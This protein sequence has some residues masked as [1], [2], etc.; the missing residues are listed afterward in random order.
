MPHDPPP[1]IRI[2]LIITELHI[3][4]AERCLVEL[5]KRLDRAKYEPTVYSL[6]PPPPQNQ[7]ALVEELHRA[8]IDVRFLGA[9]SWLSSPRVLIS[10]WRHLRRQRPQIVQSFLF[11]ANFFAAIAGRI[12]GV[13]RVIAGIR[14]AEPRKWHLQ[15]ARWTDRWITK[16]VCVSQAVASFSHTTGGLPLEKLELIPNGIDFHRFASASAVDLR[17]LGVAPGRRLITF[18]GRLDSQKGLAW[19]LPLAPRIFAQFQDHDLLIVGDGPLRQRLEQIVAELNIRPRVHFV[20]WRPDIPGILA[21]SD[22]LILPSQWEGMPNVVLEAMAAAK[23]VIACNVEGVSE[24]LGGLA[25]EQSVPPGDSDAFFNQL[26]LVLNDPART[27]EIGEKNRQRAQTEF[28]LQD[29]VVKYDRLYTSAA[30]STFRE[31]R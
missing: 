2:A 20:G 6:R 3:G 27:A 4:G 29:M 12:A 9:R 5:A 22:V 21:A 30:N 16:Y 7:A 24:L 23:P 11:H 17:T 10:L 19:F 26:A 14:V 28:D 8:G 15:L 1:P 13:S 18:V 31:R 25:R